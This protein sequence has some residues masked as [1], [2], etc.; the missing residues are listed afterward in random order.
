M[1]TCPNCGAPLGIIR[2][3]SDLRKA[4]ALT[5]EIERIIFAVAGPPGIGASHPALKHLGERKQIHNAL[6]YLTRQGNIKKV[7]RGR[8]TRP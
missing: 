5:L 7:D 4:S 1:K 6:H 8:Y 3:H 2:N